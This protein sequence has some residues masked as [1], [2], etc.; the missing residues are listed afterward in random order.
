M[1]TEDLIDALAD[2]VEPVEPLRHPAARAMG[3]MIVSFVYLA[4]L[5]WLIGPRAD[6]ADKLAEPRFVIEIAAALLTSLMAAIAAFCAGCPGRPLWERFAPFPFL[7]VWLA[8]LG[9]GC[10]RQWVQ[11]GP[12]GLTFN[13]D[14]DCFQAIFLASILSALVILVMIRQGAPLAPMS[15]TGLA[16]LAATAIGAAGLRLFH[17]LDVSVMILVWQFGSVLLLATI[18]FLA[19][20]RYLKWSL[21]KIDGGDSGHRQTG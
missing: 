6:I 12:D 5:V 9:E 1:R 10:W 13:I 21:P 14:L 4:G 16:T 3:W 2:K 15:T 7:A 19:G 8:T 20:N 17:A 11:S 18:G